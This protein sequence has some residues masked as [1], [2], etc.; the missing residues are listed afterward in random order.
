MISN[1]RNASGEHSIKHTC[2]FNTNSH[3]V[4]C[5]SFGI[6]DNQLVCRCS[7]CFPKSFD[8]GL[9]RT[10][11]CWRV[12]FVREEDRLGSNFM[13]INAPPLFHRSD[14]AVDDFTYMFNIQPSSVIGRVCS[15][16]AEEFC[17]WLNTSLLGFRMTFN[18]KRSSTHSQNESIAAAV[19]G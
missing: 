17:D 13:T 2:I 3:W 4:S 5:E 19:K 10:T 16:G 8:F 12:G 7:K 11:A 9:G 18:D 6:G 15:C 1:R 14:E